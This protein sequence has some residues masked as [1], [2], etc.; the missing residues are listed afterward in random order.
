MTAIRRAVDL[1]W[2]RAAACGLALAMAWTASNAR[3]DGCKP[4]RAKPQIMLKTMTPC[5]FDVNSLSFRGEPAQQAMCLLRAMDKSRNLEP[6]LRLLPAFLAARIGRSFD[7][8]TREVLVTYLSKN[9]LEWDFGAYLWRPLSRARDNDPD[10][11]QARYFVIHD[12]SGPN[13]GAR[14]FPADIDTRQPV[15]NL[16]MFW[17]SDNWEKA[18]VVVNRRGEMLL[19]HELSIP[20]RETKFERAVDFNGALKGLFIHVEMIQPRRRG[21]K[22]KDSQA[23]NPGFTMA[24]YDKLALLYTIASVRRGDW[25]IP[26]FHAP[27]DAEI[28]GGHDDPMNFSLDTFV[29]RLERLVAQLNGREEPQVS[30]NPPKQ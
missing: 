14:P 28:R 2:Q 7:L 21:S 10:A 26:A 11:P 18:H 24:Q 30:L 6:E 25:L 5:A 12:T 27:I 29:H 16:K 9:N 19:G 13:Y 20:W 17:C 4:T 3:A 15:N 8:P 23:P 22:G 1:G